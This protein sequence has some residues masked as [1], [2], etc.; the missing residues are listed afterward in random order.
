MATTTGFAWTPFF[1]ALAAARE[2]VL[3]LD[4]DGTLA[5][6][7]V[8]R[9][10]ARIY[11]EL[12]PI[13][14]RLAR[15]SKTRLIIISGRSLADL[16]RLLDL[17]PLP[18]LWGSHGWERRTADGIS[19]G[20][21]LDAVTRD[22]LATALARVRAFAPPEC[23]EVKPAGIALHWRGLAAG[24]V[25]VLR[26]RVEDAWGPLAEGAEL[27]LQEFDGGLELR[28]AGRDKGSAVRDVLEETGAGAVVAY[29]GDDRTDEDAFAAIEG[30]GL[31]ILARPTYRD[32]R[33][34]VWLRTPEELARFLSAWQVTDEQKG[35]LR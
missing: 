12:R 14:S 6:F 27:L 7:R 31:S 23:C 18:E 32:T 19:G 24:Q 26:R 35:G 20:P 10:K 5:P 2:R 34:D 8:D 30:R 11:P 4:Y 17:D 25:E 33:A 21:P 22:R 16:G 3:M 13:L 15:S 29:A 9:D 28:A 1:R